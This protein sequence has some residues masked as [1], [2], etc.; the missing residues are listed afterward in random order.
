MDIRALDKGNGKD[1]G[2]SKKG[3]K[4]KQGAASTREKRSEN[5]L[6]DERKDAESV[7][8]PNEN[9]NWGVFRKLSRKARRLEVVAHGQRL[10]GDG[11]RS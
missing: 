6:L 2:K 5:P 1:R 10:D 7:T 4:G 8:L 3:G 11:L 9:A